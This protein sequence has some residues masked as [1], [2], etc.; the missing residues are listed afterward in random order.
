MIRP[1][2]RAHW[3]WMVVLALTL[4][5]LLLAFLGSRDFSRHDTTLPEELIRSRQEP[6]PEVP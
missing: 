6:G 5:L 2:R 4:P 3:R 1:L